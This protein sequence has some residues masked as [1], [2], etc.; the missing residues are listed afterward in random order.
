MCFF[1][2]IPIF[3]GLNPNSHEKNHQ[4][5]MDQCLDRAGFPGRLH[6]SQQDVQTREKGAPEQTFR[7]RLTT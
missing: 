1:C 4:N 2:E 7:D 6:L 5:R 3:V